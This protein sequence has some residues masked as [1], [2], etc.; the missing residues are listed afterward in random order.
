MTKKMRVL[1]I[2]FGERENKVY[3]VGVVLHHFRLTFYASAH[4]V[5]ATWKLLTCS[6]RWQH[7]L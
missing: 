6:I 5:S 3:K 4:K 2:F 1:V 7:L